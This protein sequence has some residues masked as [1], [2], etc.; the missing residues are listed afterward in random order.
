M[1]E[2][3]IN[4]QNEIIETILEA[5]ETCS[6]GE[7]IVIKYDYILLKGKYSST[8]VFTPKEGK[9]MDANDFFMLGYFVGRDY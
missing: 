7:G 5:L 8:L 9:E 3:R 2:C 4:F 1:K 6:M